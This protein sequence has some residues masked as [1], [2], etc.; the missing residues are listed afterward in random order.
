MSRRLTRSIACTAFL[1]LIQ[2]AGLPADDE[3]SN[4]LTDSGLLTTVFRPADVDDYVAR[5]DVRH[6]VGPGVGYHEGFTS[7]GTMIPLIEDPDRG[8]VFSDIRL[9]VSNQSAV[10]ANLGIGRRVYSKKLN[11][12]FGLLAYWDMRD[13]GNHKFQ[14]L[15]LG[16]ETLGEYID[17]RTNVY[18]PDIADDKMQLPNRFAGFELLIDRTEAAMTG[19]DLEVGTSFLQFEKVRTRSY[20]GCYYFTA[21]GSP[22]IWGWKSRSEV[23]IG[24]AVSIS[25]S[26]QEDDLFGTTVNLG[27]AFRTLA[28]IRPPKPAPP[29]PPV[30]SFRRPGEE[31]ARTAVW[32]RLG[33]PVARFP[34]IVVHT[35]ETVAVDPLTGG[36]LGFLHV[37][38]GGSSDG[39]FEDPYA[40]LAEALSDS[41]AATSVIYTPR[42]GDF[43]EDIVL[44]DGTSLLSNGPLQRVATQLGDQVLPFSGADTS[45]L[46]LPQITGTVTLAS[47]SLLS[48]FDIE[49]SV[50]ATGIADAQFTSSHIRNAAATGISL[51]NSQAITLSSLTVADATNDAISLSGGS[52]ATLSD[53][54]ITNAGL[55]GVRI[56]DSNAT[57]GNITIGATT[58]GTNGIIVETGSTDRTFDISNLTVSGV[59]GTGIELNVNG[60]GNLTA[61]LTG[62]NSLSSAGNAFAAV[63][64]VAAT[65]NLEL[66]LSGTTLSSQSGTGILID[67]SDGTGTVTIT[68]FSGNTVTAANTGGVLIDTATFDSDTTTPSVIDAVAGGNMVITATGDGLRLDSPTGE[69]GF[70]SLTISNASGSGLLVDTTPAGTTFTLTSDG[71][72]I[73]TTGGPVINLQAATVDLEF[74]TVTSTGSDSNGIALDTIGGTLNIGTTTISDSFGDGI[75]VQNSASLSSGSLV[76]LPA[77]SGQAELFFLPHHHDLAHPSELHYFEQLFDNHHY[78]WLDQ[79]P[80][81]PGLDIFYDFRDQNGFTNEITTEQQTLVALAL[82]KWSDATGGTI[83]FTQKLEAEA[84][85]SD[86]INFGT[87][88]LAAIDPSADP[89]ILGLGGGF[90]L[91]NSNHEIRNGFVW[92]DKDENWDNTVNNGDPPG[93]IDYLSVALHEAGHALGLNHTSDSSDIMFDTYLGER[94]DLSVTDI[95]HIQSLNDPVPEANGLVVNFGATTITRSNAG[96]PAATAINADNSNAGNALLVFSSLNITNANGNGLIADQT[97][98]IDVNSAAA[99][100]SAITVVNGRALDIRN[101]SININFDSVSAD[102]GDIAVLLNTV[103]GSLAVSGD[104]STADSGGVIQNGTDIGIKLIDSTADVSLNFMNIASATGSTGGLLFDDSGSSSTPGGGLTIANTAFSGSEPGWVGVKVTTINDTSFT[105]SN[106]VLTGSTGADQGGID[107]TVDGGGTATPN[108][109]LTLDGNSIILSGAT[110]LAVSLTATA[111]GTISPLGG[112]GNLAI[113][114]TDPLTGTTLFDANGTDANISGSLEINGNLVFP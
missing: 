21:S 99:T 85:A 72:A 37:A 84:P 77:V 13:T 54:A 80:G 15:S 88:D 20:I 62:S 60:S 23:D 102:G 57:L 16:F 107:F 42:G 89:S 52:D 2:S 75:L 36:P 63:T 94:V 87:G 34:N 7:F 76:Y 53:L 56:D 47:N 35:Q 51:V 10:G 93:T 31:V 29:Y 112:T 46:D 59:S 68:G 11:R 66:A 96:L 111:G 90:V 103:A 110:P 39:S 114:G 67:G 86:I 17:F 49:G 9:L 95:A 28:A 14:Q 58:A 70:S 55:A 41:A 12:T 71:G 83:V 74:D 97:G 98:F 73:T 108:A 78:A 4:T 1:V 19:M 91:H 24:D 106:N 101:M 25:V 69:L 50:T 3:T 44:V 45:L 5:F 61:S 104:G 43:S 82:D 32:R 81:S 100:G 33:E 8:L 26:V 38:P 64:A 40:T 92:L 48:G 65:G 109:S 22:S 27:F 113:D 30:R 6:D 18:I 105:L 79:D